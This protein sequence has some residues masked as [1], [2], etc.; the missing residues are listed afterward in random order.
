MPLTKQ[1]IADMS[2]AEISKYSNDEWMELTSQNQEQLEY[3]K[4]LRETFKKEFPDGIPKEEWIEAEG[5]VMAAPIDTS[6]HLSDVFSYIRGNKKISGVLVPRFGLVSMKSKNVPVFVYGADCKPFMEVS[7]TGFSDGKHIF[8]S[9]L[10]LRRLMKDEEDTN[11]R[12]FGV[13]PWVMHQLLHLLRNHT[14]RLNHFEKDISEAAKDMS[15]YIDLQKGF[16]REFNG[17][18]INEDGMVFSKTIR[19]NEPGFKKEDIAAYEN[20]AEETI[21]RLMT[22]KKEKEKLACQMNQPNPSGQC[23]NPGQQGQPQPGQ[24]QPGQTGQNGTQPSQ[25]GAGGQQPQSG[26][27]Q[28]QPGQNQGQGNGQDQGQDPNAQGSKNGPWDDTHNLPLEKLAQII[29]ENP[30]LNRIKDALGIPDSQALEDIGK[31]EEQTR[32]RDMVDL[33]KAMSQK[34]QLGGKYPGG[35]VVDAENERV[36]AG[37]E[38]KMNYKL[39]IRNFI[40]GDGRQF[41][42]TY[43]VPAL[44]TYVDNGDMGLAADEG[45]FLPEEIPARPDAVGIVLLDTSGSVDPNLLKEFLTEVMWLKKN[46]SEGDSASEIYVFSADTCLRG[47][48]EEITEQ[49][50]EEVIEKG[51]NVYGRGGTDFTTPLRQLM[52]SKVM[53]EKEIAFVLYF[54]DLCASIPKESDAPKN[55]NGKKI[56]FGFIC[57]PHDLNLEFARAVQ[58]WA[59]VYPIEKGMEVDMTEDGYLNGPTDK[60]KNRRAP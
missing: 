51:V 32:S 14:R 58:N 31:I 24:G 4:K 11:G 35:H 23:N 17:K 41:V 50:Y 42:E 49:N 2:E 38:G 59:A 46:K 47:E 54:T 16:G 10:W 44:L 20:L 27:G 21:A 19:E 33:Q 13:A 7:N 18:V 36:K 9:S 52:G 34:A 12:E 40:A 15:I 22:S 37:H 55:E 8:V 6:I 53:K 5:T 30:E 28:P 56:P 45:I 3:R 39:G 1:Q 57:A 26:Q 43:D 29:E 25:S 60:R 48:P